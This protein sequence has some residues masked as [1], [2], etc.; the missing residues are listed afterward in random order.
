MSSRGQVPGVAGTS[1]PVA[2]NRTASLTSRFKMVTSTM[3]AGARGS[4]GELSAASSTSDA[5]PTFRVASSKETPSSY[6]ATTASAKAKAVGS[7][8]SARPLWP[9]RTSSHRVAPSKSATL[10]S[11]KDDMVSS[12]GTESSGVYSDSDSLVKT[13]GVALAPASRLRPPSTS[14]ASR[15]T[16]A[17]VKTASKFVRRPAAPN[18][19]ST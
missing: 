4:S 3:R 17:V 11:L 5:R 14:S 16:T 9:N 15:L 8:G 18:G 6:S 7:T 1:A 13:P 19:N 12:T 2:H 10:K